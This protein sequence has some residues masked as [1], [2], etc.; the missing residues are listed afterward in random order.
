MFR[1]RAPAVAGSFYSGDKTLLTKQIESCFNHKFGPKEIK[2]QKIISA[3]VPHAGY[4][5]SGPVAAWTYSVLEKANYIILGTNHHGMGSQFAIEKEGLWKTP[6]GEVVI[7]K[8]MAEKITE[9]CNLLEYDILAHQYEHS[10][11]VQLPFLQHRFGSDFKFV[12]ISILNQSADNEFLEECRIVGKALAKVIGGKRGK[13]VVLA[14]SDFSHYLPQKTAEEIDNYLIKSIQKLDEK[15]FF[16]RIVERDASTCGFGAIA[17]AMIISKTLKSRGSKVLSYKTSGDITR[18][19]SA[20]VG[21]AS[22]IF[23]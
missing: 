14:S 7:D 12:P 20:V 6:L 21:Y 10:I 4:E 5:Y 11:E 22:I 17:V 23:Y 19:F 1:I 8:E 9:E 2:K 16:D 15:K 18:D 13:W 3:I